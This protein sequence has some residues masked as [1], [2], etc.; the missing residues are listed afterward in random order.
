M[1]YKNIARTSVDMNSVNEETQRGKRVGFVAAA[2]DTN[3]LISIRGNIEL[4]GYFSQIRWRRPSRKD[5]APSNILS[6]PTLPNISCLCISSPT[7]ASSFS[8]QER[9]VLS[10]IVSEMDL[11]MNLFQI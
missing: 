8:S 5:F 1:D 10:L 4:G 7:S 6:S 11:L 2:S 9:F 3:Q